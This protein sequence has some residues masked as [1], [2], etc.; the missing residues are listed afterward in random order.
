VTGGHLRPFRDPKS[1]LQSRPLGIIFSNLGGTK[2]GAGVGVLWPAT[3]TAVGL[4]A[5][6]VAAVSA[7][8]ALLRTKGLLVQK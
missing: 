1:S 5:A 8:V 4:A 2:V 3:A 7:A 6:A